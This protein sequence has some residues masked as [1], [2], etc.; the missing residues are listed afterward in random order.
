MDTL[1][2]RFRVKFLG[3]THWF[4]YIKI[5]Q[6][7]YHYISVN[8]AR[9]DTYVVAMYLDTTSIN[10]KKSKLHKTILLHYMIVSKEYASTSD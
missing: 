8:Q 7:R 1:A 10:I 5:S 9:Y 6:L 4:M 3:Y 2:K